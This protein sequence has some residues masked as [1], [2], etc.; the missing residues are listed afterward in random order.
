MLR[1]QL[2]GDIMCDD[3]TQHVLACRNTYTFKYPHN[4]RK[5][6]WSNSSL[7]PNHATSLTFIDHTSCIL[8]SSSSRKL[9][10]CPLNT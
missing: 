8:I 9:F 1:T 2:H 4:C 3:D 5:K 7:Q 6:H 10:D